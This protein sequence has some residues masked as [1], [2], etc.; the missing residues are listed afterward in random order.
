MKKVGLTELTRRAAARKPALGITQ[1]DEETMRNRG[2]SRTP[3]KRE[4]P[5]RTEARA[6]A[7]GLK[8]ITSH[9]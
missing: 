4:L 8:P 9:R 7:A 1:A 6:K 2:G 3:E 5:R